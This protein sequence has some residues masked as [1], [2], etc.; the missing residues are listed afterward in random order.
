MIE[1]FT[2]NRRNPG[3]WDIW[4]NTKRI[5]RIRGGPGKYIAIDERGESCPSTEFKTISTCMQFITDELMH[6]LIT[7]EGQ[8]SQVIDSWNT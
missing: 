6:E 5:F 8:E 3:H 2:I 7:V 4:D 1:Y